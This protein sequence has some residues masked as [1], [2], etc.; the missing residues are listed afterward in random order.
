MGRRLDWA[1]ALQLTE[2]WNDNQFRDGGD[3]RGQRCQ[4][5]SRT[6]STRHTGR[7][8]PSVSPASGCRREERPWRQGWQSQEP[9]QAI[10]IGLS[11]ARKEGS[12]EQAQ[13]SKRALCATSCASP[14]KARNSS[15]KLPKGLP[16]VVTGQ[17]DVVGAELVRNPN[18]D[19]ISFTGSVAVGETIMRDDAETMKRVTLE[20]GGKSPT[21][22]LD[23]A[24][25]DEAIPA[26]LGIALFNSGQACA[27]RDATSCA[28]EA[29]RGRQARPGR[30]HPRLPRQR[31]GRSQDRRRNRWCRR[32]GTSACNPTFARV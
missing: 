2:H 5:S 7:V 22:L 28:K 25:L 12:F 9:Q 24:S 16:N 19:K 6:A 8:R 17:G 29:T 15:A 13:I 1:C 10:A 21:I 18:V 32:S 20:L 3:G 27:R 30:C 14:R 31:P 26:A 11:K 23:D 4:A